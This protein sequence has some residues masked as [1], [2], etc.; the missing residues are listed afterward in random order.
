MPS[1]AQ[2]LSEV[3]ALTFDVFGTVVDWRSTIIR[4]GEEL[5]RR[6]GLEVDWAAFAD[7]WRAGYGPAMRR[8]REGELPWT[9][10]DDLHRMI[11]DSILPKHGLQGLSEEERRELNLVWHRLEPWPD[12]VAGLTRL[13]RKFIIA[14][15]S[16]GNVSLL[17]DM[18]K[19]GGLPWD[20]VLSSELAGSYKPA[21]EVYQTA[22]RLL[23]R[24]PERVMMAAAHPGDLRAAARVGMKT[25]YVRRPDEHGRGV[26]RDRPSPDDRFDLLTE[27]FVELADRLGA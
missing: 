6:K 8:V 12:A 4:E 11:L 17:V 25:A 19:H 13:K 1:P 3:E 9:I 7:D 14:T 24:A 21:P 18:A 10:I 26:D 15:L 2:D 27:S 22:C 16:N 20:T 23:G 5:G